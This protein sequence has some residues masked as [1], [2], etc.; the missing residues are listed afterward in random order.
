MVTAVIRGTSMSV[1]RQQAESLTFWA[2]K[3]CVM[4]QLTHPESSAT[5]PDDYLL[6]Y[7]QRTPPPAMRI[8]AM[9]T[10]TEDWGVRMQHFGLLYPDTSGVEFSEPCNTHST[11]IGLGRVAFCVMATTVA[12]LPLPSLDDIPPLKAVR[13][14]PHPE[15]FVWGQTQ[16]LDDESVWIVSD[17]LRLWL[18]DD[19]DRF[20]N[21]LTELGLRNMRRAGRQVPGHEECCQVPPLGSRASRASLVPA[22]S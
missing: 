9:H 13:L 1:S 7:G 12:T 6:M 19:D 20:V 3:T 15:P 21:G 10:D 16:P 22:F 14:W 18:G 11:T 2:A 4:A 8:W 5:P 17:L